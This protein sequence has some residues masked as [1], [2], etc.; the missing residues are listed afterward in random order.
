LHKLTLVI[1][2]LFV[3]LV[4]DVSYGIA[5]YGTPYGCRNVV[6]QTNALPESGNLNILTS[7]CF[8]VYYFGIVGGSS[9]VMSTISAI[10]K[11]RVVIAQFLKKFV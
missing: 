1:L 9:L 4:V 6:Y 5:T 11:K 3:G 7:P 10:W 2:I 8:L